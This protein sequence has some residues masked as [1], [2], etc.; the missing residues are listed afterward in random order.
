M[1]YKSS[2]LLF[3]AFTVLSSASSSSK[4][5]ETGSFSLS[6]TETKQSPDIFSSEELKKV[7]LERKA[8]QVYIGKIATGKKH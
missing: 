6:F 3:I 5:K 4:I 1:R 8:A 7:L 2:I